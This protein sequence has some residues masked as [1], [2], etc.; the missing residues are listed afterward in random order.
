G[1]RARVDAALAV[2]RAARIWPPLDRLTEQDAP[3]VLPLSEEEL[4]DLLGVAATR[5]A[6][7][8]VAVHWPRDLAQDLTASAVV[9]PA[10]GSATDGT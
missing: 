7:A 2:R 5:L 3:D 4:T 6:T 1:P 10:P 8:G 9:R